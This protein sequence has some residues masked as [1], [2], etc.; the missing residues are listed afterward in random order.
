[1]D[2]S[3]EGSC[4]RSGNPKIL[5]TYSSG[6]ISCQVDTFHAKCQNWVYFAWLL[7]SL[8]CLATHIRCAY[9]VQLDGCVHTFV[10]HFKSA[11]ITMSPIKRKYYNSNPY[12][13]VLLLF[14]IMLHYA[15]YV[16]I[17]SVLNKYDC[18][19]L[20]PTTGIVSDQA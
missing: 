9:L 16:R 17:D 10:R 8:H 5:F 6:F 4:K 2:F 3:M 14:Y 18:G 15:K 11:V 7:M 13:L 19:S 12:T 20:E 1:M